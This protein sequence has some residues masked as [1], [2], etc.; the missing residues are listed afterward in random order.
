ME[1]TR[2]D[3]Q[4][5]CKEEQS[6]EDQLDEPHEANFKDMEE[7]DKAGENLNCDDLIIFVCV[8]TLHQ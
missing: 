6:V 7:E 1:D 8:Q 2:A 3:L 4:E 5:G